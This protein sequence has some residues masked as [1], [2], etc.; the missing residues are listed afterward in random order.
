LE[1][2]QAAKLQTKS[3]GLSENRK[4]HTSSSA[5]EALGYLSLNPLGNE[6]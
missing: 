1:D 6:I 4:R 3:S 5:K 2:G